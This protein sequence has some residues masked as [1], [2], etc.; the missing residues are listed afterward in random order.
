VV[1]R[2][3]GIK[4]FVQPLRDQA[5]FVAAWSLL[6]F[7]AAAITLLPFSVVRRILGQTAAPAEDPLLPDLTKQLQWRAYS[8]AVSI[9]RAARRSPWRA[10][11]YPQALTAR[12]MLTVQRVPHSIS[13]GL[14]RTDGQLL[15]HAWVRAGDIPVTGGPA[16]EFTEVSSFH[17]IPGA[18]RRRTGH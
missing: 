9:E 11:C 6:A 17:W 13:F 10:D 14:R 4:H 16:H 7:N 2:K 15:A 8:T 12:M 1:R 5:R 3:D 18:A